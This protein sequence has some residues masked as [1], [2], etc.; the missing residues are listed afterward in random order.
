MKQ[1]DCLKK[2]SDPL[3]SPGQKIIFCCSEKSA[4]FTKSEYK[5]YAMYL[6]QLLKLAVSPEVK[7]AA[8]SW[9]LRATWDINAT[10][11]NDAHVM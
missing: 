7:K 3:I 11:A 10:I 4:I 1:A 8:H 9:N 6:T 2:L 5:L